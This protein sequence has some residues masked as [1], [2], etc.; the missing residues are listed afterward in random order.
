MLR[1]LFLS[2]TSALLLGCPGPEPVCGAGDA[3][4]DGLTAVEGGVTIRYGDFMASANNDCPAPGGGVTSVTVFG[5]QIE[6]TGNAV[7]A[8]CLP[9][10]DALSGEIDLV[11]VHEPALDSDRVQVVDVE[12]VP[13]AD[14][15][16]SFEGEPDGT[17]TFEGFCD[18]GAHADGFALTLDA[19]LP[20][21]KTCTGDPD[22]DVE[23][24]L[25]GTVAVTPQ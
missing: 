18:N 3:P 14:C 9:R 10:P 11:P 25:A 5:H 4:A 6:P 15:R 12:G 13:D 16:W 17:A 21:V 2:S 19:T 7:I 20:A 24:T 22:A 23:V 8:F 1:W